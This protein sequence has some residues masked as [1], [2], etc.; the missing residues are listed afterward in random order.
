MSQEWRMGAEPF[1]VTL[2]GLAKQHRPGEEYGALIMELLGQVWS[3]IRGRAL[4]NLGRNHVIYEEDGSVFAGVELV[5]QIAGAE[6]AGSG[7]DLM[8][9]SLTLPAY[10]Y[11]V[12][13]GPYGE[14]G[15][16]YDAL[17]AA[18]RASGR[19]CRRPLLEIYGHWQEDESLLETEIYYSLR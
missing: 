6:S 15:R 7:P 4:P 9:K 13:R 2:H 16:T 19:E 3:E 10:A 12:H 1:S 18:V 11:C 17:V 5:T 14:L 8:A